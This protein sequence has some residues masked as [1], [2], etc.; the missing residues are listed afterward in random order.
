M[1][2]KE[3]NFCSF[4]QNEKETLTHLFFDCIHVQ[5][6]WRQIKEWIENT[7]HATINLSRK[8]VCLGCLEYRNRVL[9]LLITVIKYN[10][11]NRNCKE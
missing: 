6:I 8:V 9:N 2:V 1:S 3:T 5:T 7:T 10:I 4:C 11:L